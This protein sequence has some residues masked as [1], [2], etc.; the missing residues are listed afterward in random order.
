MDYD[1]LSDEELRLV[2]DFEERGDA[3]STLELELVAAIEQK[4]ASEPEPELEIAPFVRPEKSGLRQGVDQVEEFLKGIPSGGIGY[5]EQA[6][7]GAAAALPEDWETPV[8]DV[9]L[10]VA[11][12]LKS[13]FTAD[14]GDEGLAG[15][16][17]G[18]GLGSFA[19]LLGVS[20]IPYAG[21]YLAAG[22][23]IA[24]Q[25][26]EASE[27]ARLEDA[28]VEDRGTAALFA[29]PVGLLDLIPIKVL[30]VLREAGKGVIGTAVNRVKRA[31]IEG[32]VEAAQESATAIAQNIISRSV[33]NPEQ[34][35][36]G[37]VGEAAAIGGG[38]GAIAQA[39][40]DLALPRSR[41]SGTVAVEDS[42]PVDEAV[43]DEALSSSAVADAVAEVSGDGEAVV[44]V[45]D[46]AKAEEAR[47][48]AEQAE[49]D[50]RWADLTFEPTPEDIA[51]GDI[52]RANLAAAMA[53]SEAE[54][55]PEVAPE[56]VTEAVTEGEAVTEAGIEGDLTKIRVEAFDAGVAAEAEAKA[57]AEIE[58][59]ALAE[60]QVKADAEAE[61]DAALAEY[62][63]TGATDATEV[64]DA[65][66]EGATVE[67]A[68]VEGATGPE[69]T[70]AGSNTINDYQQRIFKSLGV[71]FD[72][73][74][75][76][77]LL[78]GEEIDLNAALQTV[79]NES[80]Q[81]TKRSQAE[82]VR[83]AEIAKFLTGT[84]PKAGTEVVTE[85]V[86]EGGAEV[87]TPEVVT[88]EVVAA[89]PTLPLLL[90]LCKRH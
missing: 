8:R 78:K 30:G 74:V 52:D 83:D 73:P 18:E 26:G 3:L 84:A 4:Y 49:A 57:K 31:G 39:L 14:A 6:A 1:L 70:E 27:R 44:E 13:P 22:S 55:A 40:M 61:A 60:A 46:E 58:A 65:T 12:G 89:T 69:V 64:T 37:G 48:V 23:A 90:L 86:T 15:R 82:G 35:L 45:L 63:S 16:K 67:G 88:P 41:T 36:L 43:I 85:V 51:K 76:A 79:L 56:A 71:S 62:I 47:I 24:A 25:A 9:I 7:L 19:G 53:R 20:T 10:D 81:N 38:V 54:A 11:G 29:A 72:T 87:V 2:A 68:T 66:V 17:L 32:G 28:S 42:D 33:Y 59:K 80:V 77:R 34:A 75:G 5:L 21:Q 50:K